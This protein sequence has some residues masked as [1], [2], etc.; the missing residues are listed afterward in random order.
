MFEP[1]FRPTKLCNWEVPRKTSRRPSVCK[2]PT[3]VICD[4]NGRFLSADL[5]PKSSPWAKYKSTWQLPDRI[6]RYQANELNE[7]L[8]KRKI[9]G[10]DNK[11][12]KGGEQSPQ[13][14]GNEQTQYTQTAPQPLVYPNVQ[15]PNQLQVM[16]PGKISDRY[17]P[18]DFTEPEQQHSSRLTLLQQNL[19][20]D[21]DNKEELPLNPLYIEQHKCT[22]TIALL[23]EQEKRLREKIPHV[24][25]DN[26]EDNFENM[27][28]QTHIPDKPTERNPS[29]LIPAYCNFE[30]A[31]RMAQ[32]NL[33]HQPLPDCIMD[34]AF[35]KIQAQGDSYPGLALDVIPSA[36]GV[37]IKTYKAGPTHCTK[38]KVYRPKTCGVVPKAVG[39]SQMHRPQTCYPGNQK[40]SSMDL[41]ICWDYRPANPMDEPQPPKHIDGSNG[42]AA[43]AVFTLVKTPRTPEKLDT[44]RSA[45]IFTNTLGNEGFFEKDIVRRKTNFS[46]QRSKSGLKCSC[47]TSPMSMASAKS[48]RSQSATRDAALKSNTKRSESSPNLSQIVNV[49]ES[50]MYR[51]N[52]YRNYN[53]HIPRKKEHTCSKYG[54]KNRDMHVL[55]RTERLCQKFEPQQYPELAPRETYKPAFKAGV[56]KSN[57]SGTVTSFDSGCSTMSSGTCSTK[58]LNIP[59]PRHPYAKKN[60]NIDTLVPPFACIKGGAG[61][62]GYPEH[63]R[64]AS[65]YQHAYKPIDQRKRP[66]LQTIYK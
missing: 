50:A 48:S 3:Q 39:E 53:Q 24:L 20:N 38:M 16:Q 8:P 13:S 10:K 37:G 7:T 21:S 2:V 1:A 29:P 46:A 26:V 63:W 14:T 66:L 35:R 33:E 52:H 11:S 22:D 58:V 19:N 23:E 30:M 47:G 59:K 32:E 40:M 45:G 41:A 36:S 42:S 28:I 5:R 51:G 9:A 65:V 15:D 17:I 64:L 49:S 60:Y 62:G 43:P 27:K 6:T 25:G 12:R 4:E 54:P 31:K 55:K 44:G 18:G 61:Q 56:P 57:A 34:R